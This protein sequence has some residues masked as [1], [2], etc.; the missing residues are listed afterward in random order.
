MWV[1]RRKYSWIHVVVA[2]YLWRH[3][4]ETCWNTPEVQGMHKAYK[5]F[6]RWK[7]HSV[8]AKRWN[9]TKEIEF[10]THDLSEWRQLKGQENNLSDR[11]GGE[12]HTKSQLQVCFQS[13]ACFVK[14]SSQPYFLHL[15]ATWISLIPNK[16]PESLLC[17][18]LGLCW[19]LALVLWLRML[20]DLLIRYNI[21][22][23]FSLALLPEIYQQI[24]KYIFLFVFHCL[25][26]FLP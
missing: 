19:C 17:F 9:E 23:L 8:S 10:N 14:T 26:F 2:I 25:P 3:L 1:L 24:S 20:H 15:Q 5:L 16:C 6:T 22:I 7:S 11:Q 21:C 13:A 12:A 18:L 4:W